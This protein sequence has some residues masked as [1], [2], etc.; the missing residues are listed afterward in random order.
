[1]TQKNSAAVL[2]GIILE[3]ESANQE[4]ESRMANVNGYVE[5]T[6]GDE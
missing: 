4:N 6:C 3:S 1:M 2:P 5:E